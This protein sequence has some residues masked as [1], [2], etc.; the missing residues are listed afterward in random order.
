MLRLYTNL[1]LV[2]VDGHMHL[3]AK[4]SIH[5]YMLGLSGIENLALQLLQQSHCDHCHN[6]ALEYFTIINRAQ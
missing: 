2:M 4:P 3:G 5:V 1:E 6:I